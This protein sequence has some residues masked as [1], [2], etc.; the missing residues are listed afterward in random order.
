MRYTLFIAY[1]LTCLNIYILIVSDA[2]TSGVF[3]KGRNP[4]LWSTSYPTQPQRG[5]LSQPTII[6]ASEPWHGDLTQLVADT[7]ETNGEC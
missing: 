1:C 4:E 5:D 7:P 2:S 6:Y 3:D